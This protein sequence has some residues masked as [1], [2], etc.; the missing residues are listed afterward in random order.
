MYGWKWFFAKTKLASRHKVVFFVV[1]SLNGWEGVREKKIEG[2]RG[3]ADE[4]HEEQ[5]N[6]KAPI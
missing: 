3:N 6:S 2:M 5:E 1:K 4:C